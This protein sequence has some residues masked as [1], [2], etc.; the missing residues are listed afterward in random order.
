MG[1]RVRERECV[2]VCVGRNV[3][4]SATAGDGCVVIS[5]S[6]V[7]LLTQLLLPIVEKIEKVT[8]CMT[9]AASYQ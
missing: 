4:W 2:C 3:R 6:T 1:E 5:V 9:R 8:V 7:T